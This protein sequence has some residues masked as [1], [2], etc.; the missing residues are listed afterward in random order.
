[1]VIQLL[2]Q[3]S[4]RYLGEPE[5]TRAALD[6]EGYYHTGDMVDLRDG[7]LLL[8]GRERDDCKFQGC[9]RPNAALFVPVV[10]N[11]S[12]SHLQISFMVA[13]GHRPLKLND[14]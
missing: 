6:E 12:F 13:P 2:K 10:D 5:K 14:A 1:M 11:F 9:L 8:L 3:M 4:C 7:E